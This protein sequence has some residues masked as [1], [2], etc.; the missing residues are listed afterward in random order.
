M[1]KAIEKIAVE[2][3][4]EIVLKVGIEN[5]EENTVENIKKADVVIEFTN[6]ESAFENVSKSLLA[7]VPVVCGSTGW[8]DKFAEAKAICE[9]NN[10]AFIVASNYSVGVNLFFEINKLAARIMK[11]HKEYTVA[12]EETHHTQKLDAPSGTAISIAEQIL[13]SYSHLNK[14]SLEETNPEALPIKAFRVE[15][16]PGTHVVKYTSK[17]DDIELSHTAHNREGFALGAVVAAEYIHDK[18]G[19]FTMHDVLFSNL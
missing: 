7:G 19:N 14:W 11:P 18:K 10:T 5:L 17:I 2:R 12:V 13:E 6:P 15:D 8:N 1:G 16:V 3:G 4:H 9:Q